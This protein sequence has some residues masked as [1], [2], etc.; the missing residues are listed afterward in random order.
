MTWTRQ[1]EYEIS[2]KQSRSIQSIST[3]EAVW[4]DLINKIRLKS[5]RT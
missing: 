3:L 5:Q 1:C 4:T 2:G